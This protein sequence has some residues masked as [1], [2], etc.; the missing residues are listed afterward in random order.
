VYPFVS[1]TVTLE[2]PTDLVQLMAE[3]KSSEHMEAAIDSV[4]RLHVREDHMQAM[5]LIPGNRG[6]IETPIG[7]PN[8]AGPVA[9]DGAEIRHPVRE[10]LIQI[11]R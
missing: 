5:A 8:Q 3:V 9:G 1:W 7:R 11:R 10:R 6:R 2:T 4:I